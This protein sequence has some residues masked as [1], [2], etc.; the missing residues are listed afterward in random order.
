LERVRERTIHKSKTKICVEIAKNL[1]PNP[2]P[3]G[4]N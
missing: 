1:S 3:E 2:S 4:S